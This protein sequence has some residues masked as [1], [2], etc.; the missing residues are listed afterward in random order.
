MQG[1]LLGKSRDKAGVS[2]SRVLVLHQEYGCDTGCCGHVVQVDG[3]LVGYFDFG[4]PY[5]RS[6]DSIEEYVRELVTKHC[7]ADHVK[8]IDWAGCIVLDD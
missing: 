5:D 3:A 2:M 7:G 8:D 1:P 4:H 6:K